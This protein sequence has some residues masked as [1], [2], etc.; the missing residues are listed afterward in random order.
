MSNKFCSI[1]TADFKKKSANNRFKTPLFMFFAEPNGLDF[2]RYGII[3]TKKSGNAIKRNKIRRWIKNSLHQNID[4][5]SSLDYI[6]IV[7]KFYN[8][9]RATFDLINKNIQDAIVNI[10]K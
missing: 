8:F 1:K 7:N 2:S 9:N 10:N 3:I 6:I 5:E 4:K